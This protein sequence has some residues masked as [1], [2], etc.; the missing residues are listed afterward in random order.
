MARDSLGFAYPAREV[1]RLPAAPE[2]FGIGDTFNTAVQVLFRNAVP[3]G[4]ITAVVGI[5]YIVMVLAGV[6]P[7]PVISPVSFTD[8][9]MNFDWKVTPAGFVLGLIYLLVQCAL[10]YGTFLSLLRKP[11]ALGRCFARGLGAAIKVVLASII[12][13]IVIGAVVFVATNLVLL[14]PL[15]GLLIVPA[16][17]ISFV[18]LYVLWWVVIPVLVVEGGFIECFRRSRALTK[19]N[20]WEIL[21]LSLII[22]VTEAAVSQGVAVLTVALGPALR[23]VL[24]VVIVLIFVAFTA[25][26]KTVG[27]YKLRAGKEGINAE[28]L[29]AVFD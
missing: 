16:I 24:T 5:P 7:P 17:V 13:L 3:F 6:V 1:Q 10:T 20:R 2:R 11:V 14:K 22:L 25:V 28:Q 4:V 19:G 21:G 15:L 23:D 8:F 29:A 12:V 26:L 27:Y 18:V 9:K